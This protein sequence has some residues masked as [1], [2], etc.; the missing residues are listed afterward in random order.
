MAQRTYCNTVNH[1]MAQRTYCNT[2]I[3]IIWLKELIAIQLTI[4]WLKENSDS[5]KSAIIFTDRL[6]VLTSLQTCKSK[7]N[8]SLLENTLD[9]IH[10]LRLH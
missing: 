4:I 8:P 5:N 10:I 6:S 3:T 2:V 9:Q 7:S 1:N